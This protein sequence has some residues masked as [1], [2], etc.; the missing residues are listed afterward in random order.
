MGKEPVSRSALPRAHFDLG[1]LS[2]EA[3]PDVVRRMQEQRELMRIAAV[4]ALQHSD[5]GRRLTPD[6]RRWALHWAKVKPLGRALSDG[7]PG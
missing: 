5:G 4:R 6:A 7:V 3:P 1:P 2:Q